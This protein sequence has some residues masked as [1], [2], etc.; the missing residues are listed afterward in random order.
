MIA[1]DQ[2]PS[3]RGRGPRVPAALAGRIPEGP[4]GWPGVYGYVSNSSWGAVGGGDGSAQ[5]L[6]PFGAAA[7]NDSYVV[8]DRPITL[9]VS[10][11]REL[12]IRARS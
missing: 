5:P 6:D 9:N 2:T 4:P 3:G 1:L 10:E 7:D 11:Q 12:R 8:T